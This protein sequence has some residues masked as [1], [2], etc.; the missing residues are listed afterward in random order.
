MGFL[1]NIRA[2]DE[3]DQKAAKYDDMVKQN[4]YKLVYQKGLA[5][6]ANRIAQEMQ[7]AQVMKMQQEAMA[8]QM[9]PQP[10]QPM[11]PGL[12]QQSIIQ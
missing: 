5:D 2:R 11:M 1:D 6:S 8:A 12:A 3:K 10:Q 4:E 7:A 9:A